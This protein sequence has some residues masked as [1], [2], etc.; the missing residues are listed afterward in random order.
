MSESLQQNIEVQAF[1]SEVERQN[2]IQ[3]QL[4]EILH[5]IDAQPA[6]VSTFEELEKARSSL[7]NFRKSQIG[8]AERVH[9][10][11]KEL[12]SLSAESEL[13]IIHGSAVSDFSH[14][15]RQKESEHRLIT[16]AHQRLI[17]QMIPEAE[18]SEMK[19]FAN[20]L[21]AKARATR[22]EATS[23]IEQ[24]AQL[25][26]QAAAFEGH[27][28]FDPANTLSGALVAHAEEMETQVDQYRRWASERTEK[29]QR[30]LKE[31]ESI[32]LL[33]G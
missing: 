4:I 30:I 1:H 9:L 23:R 19:Y 26:A 3:Q 5:R 18:I 15:I 8:L 10:L 17:E 16:R 29:H 32:K 22:E 21:A 13:A 14:P 31:L 25:M 12:A 20:H 2:A 6:V 7:K 27:I 28:S 33:R 11:G 24:T